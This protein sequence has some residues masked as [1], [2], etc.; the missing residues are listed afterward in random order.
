MAMCAKCGLLGLRNETTGE[1][2]EVD[3]RTRATGEVGRNRIGPILCCGNETSFPQNAAQTKAELDK[4]KTCERFFHWRAGF[5]PKEHAQMIDF[6]SARDAQREREE[7]D[8]RWRE[9]DEKRNREWRQEDLRLLHADMKIKAIV[10][11]FAAM[12]GGFI[13]AVGG[14]AGVLLGF[15]LKPK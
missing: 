13:G 7:S 2:A 4:E 3:E 9:E 14:V 6:Q 8:R 15:Y 10:P 12:V 1:I 5:S 11:I